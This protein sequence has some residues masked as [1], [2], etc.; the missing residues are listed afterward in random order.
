MSAARRRAS[1]ARRCSPLVA[2]APAGAS[3]GVA[4]PADPPPSRLLVTAREY[5][6][7]LSKPKIDAGPSIIQ[8]YNYGEDPHDLELQRVGG[9]TVIELGE[10]VP[11]ETGQLDL[12]LR[13]KSTL[14]A[15]VL[16]P[17]PRRARHGGY[18]EDVGEA[19]A[20]SAGSVRLRPSGVE[21]RLELGGRQPTGA[22]QLKRSQT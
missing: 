14:H 18:A 1:P 3:A 7:T 19:P 9:P 15:L 2:L 8:L 10:V 12:K 4:D 21:Q 13:R 20:A 6:F 17:G 16:D 5:C 11:G 22:R